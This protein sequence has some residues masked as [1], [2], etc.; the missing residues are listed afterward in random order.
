MALFGIFGQGSLYRKELIDRL[1]RGELKIHG[2][3]AG[4]ENMLLRA[5]CA[6]ALPLLDLRFLFCCCLRIAF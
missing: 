4:L 6:K 5:L 2:R 1:L 3:A